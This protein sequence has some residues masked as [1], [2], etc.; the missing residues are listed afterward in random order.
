MHR[1]RLIQHYVGTS[2]YR[3]SYYIQL[4]AAARSGG[5]YQT[6]PDTARHHKPAHRAPLERPQIPGGH[7]SAADHPLPPLWPAVSPSERA[8]VTGKH[9]GR[10][11]VNCDALAAGITWHWSDDVTSCSE[12]APAAAVWPEG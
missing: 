1:V 12:L 3:Q 7:L 10:G 4:S 9:Y 2:C 11:R 8:S 5:H 6:M